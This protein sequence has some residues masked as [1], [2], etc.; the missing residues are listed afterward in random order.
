[1]LFYFFM[2]NDLSFINTTQKAFKLS[3]KSVSMPRMDEKKPH[4]WE[5]QLKRS[6]RNMRRKLLQKEFARKITECSKHLRHI[7]I[8]KNI[9]SELNRCIFQ[10]PLKYIKLIIPSWRGV[11][12]LKA[13]LKP[14]PLIQNRVQQDY[15]PESYGS[16]LPSYQKCRK[17]VAPTRS[18]GLFPLPLNLYGY[19]WGWRKILP[20][21]QKFTHLPQ[22]KN[23]L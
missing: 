12:A 1:M 2:C 22:Q 6:S 18:C 17:I 7:A 11:L 8:E 15:L 9:S 14:S 16:H 4:T 10:I 5:F 23:P 13:Q 19:H 20:N 21:S 3:V